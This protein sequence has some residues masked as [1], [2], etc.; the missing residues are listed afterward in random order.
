MPLL[1]DYQ[2]KIDD[3]GSQYYDI[4]LNMFP[5]KISQFMKEDNLLLCPDFQRGRVWTTEQQ[6]LFC[7]FVLKR[8]KYFPLLFNH[9]G[10]YADFEGQMVCV[11]GL[12]RITAILAMMDGE[13]CVFGHKFSEFDDKV[14]YGRM[15]NIPI[16]IHSLKTKKA[17][18]EWYLQV[19]TT[20]TPHTQEEI[21]RVLKLKEQTLD[22]DLY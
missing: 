6:I 5:E 17:V 18:L 15:I 11:D 20:G 1:Q 9:P 3:I 10:W 16:R 12:Q 8:G 22:T 19:N 2:F 13:I 4:P 14:R 7:E 21:D